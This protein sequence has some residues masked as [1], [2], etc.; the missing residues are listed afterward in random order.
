MLNIRSSLLES[1]KNFSNLSIRTTYRK[2][3]FQRNFHPKKTEDFASAH[4]Q[5]QWNQEHGNLSYACIEDKI[6]QIK[7]SVEFQNDPHKFIESYKNKERCPELKEAI[8]T[9]FNNQFL[10]LR[11]KK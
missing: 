5:K 6:K 3:S 7:N 9:Y 1:L 8:I 2:N 10:T 4:F 11:I